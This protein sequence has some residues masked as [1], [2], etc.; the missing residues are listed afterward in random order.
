MSKIEVLR[1]CRERRWFEAWEGMVPAGRAPEAEACLC[2]AI[3]EIIAL[4]PEPR[5]RDVRRVVERV[6]ERFNAMDTAEGQSPWI[7]TT[8]REDIYYALEEIVGLTGIECADFE[9]WFWNA[10]W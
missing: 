10:D 3:D 4:G 6:V 7:M 2:Q 1:R 8:E 9:D 5:K